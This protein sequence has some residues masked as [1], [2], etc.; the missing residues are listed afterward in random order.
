MQRDRSKIDRSLTQILESLARIVVPAG[1]SFGHV[2]RIARAAYVGAALEEELKLHARPSIA[3]IA[4][5]TG[6]T[7]VEVSKVLKAGGRG[8][9]LPLQS[10]SRSANV[11]AGWIA[12][13]AFTDKRGKPIALPFAGR[14]ATFTS[15]AKK[16]SG[17]IPA[18]A[19]L[20]EMKRTRMVRQSAGGAIRLLRTEGKIDR[21]TISALDAIRPWIDILA[22][23]SDPVAQE[24]LTSTTQHV[25]VEFDS[26]PQMFAAIRILNERSQAF[27]ESISQMG[28]VTRDED[29]LAVRFT[30]AI[31]ASNP[32]RK[33]LAKQRKK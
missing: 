4:A 22:K 6:L 17:D 25:R 16:Y 8:K 1:V 32:S 19:M 12:D 18:R 15:L 14:G 20:N 24:D 30:V 5:S 33:C 13:S 23:L 10:L 28:S 3:K 31:A 7:R 21:Q 2:M 9:M 27:V 11:A 26:A 29:K